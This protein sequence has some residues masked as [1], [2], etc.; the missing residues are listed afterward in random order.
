MRPLPATAK[1][2]RTRMAM[3]EAAA[4]LMYQR[5]IT[6]TGVEDV[7]SAS[8]TGKSQM[9]HYFGDKQ[10]LVAAVLEHQLGRVLAAQPSLTDE[11]GDDLGR[12][13]DEVLRAFRDSGCGNC[14]LGV[15]TGQVDGDPALREV[16]TGLFDRWQQAIT[17]LVAR[18]RRAERVP[19]DT[20]APEAGLA[21]LTALQGGTMLAHLRKDEGPLA[22]ALDSALSGVLPGQ[23]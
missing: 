3:I 9:Y 20:D 13:R 11:A 5:G 14:P 10:G 23:R 19:A 17:D 12:W 21:L 7:L 1:G 8:D 2:R 18:A 6:S 16:L 15:F 22:H 4:L